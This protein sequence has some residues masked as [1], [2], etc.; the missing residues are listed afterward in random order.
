MTGSKLKIDTAVIAA[1]G[2][3]ARLSPLTL[4][5]PKPMVG[6]VDRPL[7][8]Y[9]IDQIAA[10]GIKNFIVVINPQFQA[11]KNYINYQIK[12]GAWPG[13]RL[14]II[15]KNSKG[16]ADSVLAAE[17]FIGQ[18]HFLAASSD[19]LFDDKLPPFHELLKVFNDFRKPVAVLRRIK[20]SETGHW[21]VV[22][23]SKAAKDLWNISDLIEKPSPKEA[24]SVLGSIANYILPPEIFSFIK[25]MKK[26]IPAAKEPTVI[27][28][29]KLYLASGGKLLG[30][31]FR[32]HHFDGGSKIGLLKA[33]AHFAL[34]HP[35]FGSAFKKYLRLL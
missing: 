26:S 1:A 27:D 5:Q 3:G 9:V 29:L 6:I 17:K 24:P 35:E 14:R 34:K 30:W 20:K 33:S 23:A 16:F 15:E 28:A 21:G 22:S 13:C 7:I 32:G 19:D 11:I 25:L 2:F 4:H 18:N 10:G 12:E 8:H 31:V